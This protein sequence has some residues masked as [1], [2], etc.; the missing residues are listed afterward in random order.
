VTG[1]RFEQLPEPVRLE[2]TI[3]SE[4]VRHA[5]PVT[6]LVVDAW[7]IRNAAG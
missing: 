5:E 2:D 7:L 4:D 1:R 3:T 6:D